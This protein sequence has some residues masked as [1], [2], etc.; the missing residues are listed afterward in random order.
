MSPFVWATHHYGW[1]ANAARKRLLPKVREALGLSAPLARTR[2]PVEPETWEATLLR[3]TG[4]DV[5]RCPCCGA[6][7]FRIVEAVPPRAE[8]GNLP[9][10]VRSP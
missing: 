1:L 4:K 9:L 2:P 10:R 3:L 6:G 8:P 7:G 5:T